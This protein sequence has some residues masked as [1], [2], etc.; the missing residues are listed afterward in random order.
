MFDRFRDSSSRPSYPLQYMQES[1]PSYTY[2]ETLT[3]IPRATKRKNKNGLR[4]YSRRVGR[5]LVKT[6]LPIE[7]GAEKSKQNRK[8]KQL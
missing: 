2:T 1:L 8:E 7:V 5:R 6:Y 4:S 3:Y